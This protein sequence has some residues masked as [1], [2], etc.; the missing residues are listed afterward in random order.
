MTKCARSSRGTRGL[1]T[2]ADKRA[3][4][5]PEKSGDSRHLESSRGSSAFA[6]NLLQTN[7]LY[8][9]IPLKPAPMRESTG[10]APNLVLLYAHFGL[11]RENGFHPPAVS[12]QKSSEL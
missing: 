9:N 10:F 1:P 2:L 11:G 12:Q 8:E 3:L 7:V 4:V 5:S 6:C